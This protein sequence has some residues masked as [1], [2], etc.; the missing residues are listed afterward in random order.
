[1]IQVQYGTEMLYWNPLVPYHDNKT[2]QATEV[3]GCYF[4][5]LDLPLWEVN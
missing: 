2:E 1:M 3:K 4:S 5:C